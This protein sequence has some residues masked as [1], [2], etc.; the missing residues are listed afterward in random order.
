[1]KEKLKEVAKG[2]MAIL[3]VALVVMVVT[4]VLDDLYDFRLLMAAAGG[5]FGFEPLKKLFSKI[6]GLE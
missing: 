6:K 4:R 3:S 1:M 2:S 5:A